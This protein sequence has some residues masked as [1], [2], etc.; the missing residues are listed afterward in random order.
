MPELVRQLKDQFGDSQPTFG[1]GWNIT[2][3]FA[4][5]QATV[6]GVSFLALGAPRRMALTW[7]VYGTASVNMHVGK[8]FAPHCFSIHVLLLQTRV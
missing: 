5:S 8:P 7:F 1:T 6:Q 3:D 2:L 4:S